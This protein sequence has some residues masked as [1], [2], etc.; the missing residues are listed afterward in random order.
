MPIH[1]DDVETLH[2][3][4]VGVMA[5][6]QHDAPKVRAV[7][8]AILGGIIWR[9]DPG[10]IEIRF[11]ERNLGNALRWISGSGREYVCTYNHHAGQLEMHDQSREG[12]ALHSFTNETPI[13][14]IERIFSTL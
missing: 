2:D 14:D 6:G 12:A 11:G 10:S 5:R 4:A 9:V 7:A 1:A 8:L 3:F 13:T